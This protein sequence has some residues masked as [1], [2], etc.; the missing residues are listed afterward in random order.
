MAEPLAVRIFAKP[1]AEVDRILGKPRAVGS[2]HRFHEYSRVGG[3]YYVV[4]ESGRSTLVTVTLRQPAS[5]AAQALA[6]IGFSMGG[7]KPVSQGPL[8]VRWERLLGIPVVVVKAT[9]GKHWDTIEL[10][11]R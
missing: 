1:H 10:R 9:A 6:N 4:F 11:R 7:R 5:S 8:E 3:G 2:G